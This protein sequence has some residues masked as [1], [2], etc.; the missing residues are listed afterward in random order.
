[1]KPYPSSF[2][3]PRP[4]SIDILGAIDHQPGATHPCI[5]A[6][7]GTHSCVGQSPARRSALAL[8]PAPFAPLGRALWEFP[9]GGF[10]CC[11]SCQSRLGGCPAVGSF[12]RPAVLPP[13]YP[14]SRPSVART[15]LSL[16]DRPPPP[17]RWLSLAQKP[18]P[19]SCE[20]PPCPS[21]CTTCF[22]A[23]RFLELSTYVPSRPPHPPKP[24]EPRWFRL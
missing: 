5:H 23:L 15:P 13:A 9:R 19:E 20:N 17:L 16:G 3:N 1:M 6:S 8:S 11:P 14:G 10:P 22:L 12:L 18:A 7:D 21:G 4:P 2:S 24:I